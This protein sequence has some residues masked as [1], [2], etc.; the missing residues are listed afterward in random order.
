M[1]DG[2]RGDGERREAGRAAQSFLRTTVRDVDTGRIDVDGDA[3]ERGDTIGDDERT[4]GSRGSRDRE[5]GLR[6]AGRG[7]GMNEGDELGTFA[8]E[9]FGGLGFSENFAPGLFEADDGGAVAAAH[10]RETLAK[11]A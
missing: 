2:A 5:G 11:I 8:L 10:F 4:D 1:V 6:G 7:F 9:E 3:A